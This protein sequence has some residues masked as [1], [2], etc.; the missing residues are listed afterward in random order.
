MSA[1]LDRKPALVFIGFMGAGKSKAARAA[2]GAGLESLD[3]DLELER[4]LDMPI[5][6]FFAA[7]GE[8]E[9]RARERELV[10]K[11]LDRAD[12][13]ALALGGGSVLADE[14]RESLERHVVVWLD[15]G[16]DEAWE[17]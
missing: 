16:V 17:R 9:F 8:D 5:P 6:D 1:A 3:A 7:R 10:V 4:A 14:V 15:V 11:L 12:G 2:R 13:G